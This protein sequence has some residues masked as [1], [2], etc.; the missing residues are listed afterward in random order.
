VSR[1]KRNGRDGIAVRAFE[2]AVP[3]VFANSVG[4]QGG[5]RWSAGDSKIVAADGTVLRLAGNFRE[6][7]IIAELDLTQ[8]TGKYAV[9]GVSSPQFLT[10]GWRR[11]I[12]KVQAQARA[13]AKRWR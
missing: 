13:G 10:V 5:G 11:M 2:N 1:R 8:A 9:E 12:A 4:P 3:Y 6:A 7:L